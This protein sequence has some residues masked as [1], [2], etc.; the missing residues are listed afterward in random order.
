MALAWD[1]SFAAFRPGNERVE[2]WIRRYALGGLTSPYGCE[3]AVVY[4]L[5]APVADHYFFI[6]DDEPKQV[7]L[8]TKGYRYVSVSDPVSGDELLLG[9]PISLEAH[10]GRWLRYV[11]R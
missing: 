10:S 9:G 3:G 8:D 7:T 6:N 4:R 2:T 11:K 5:A 1:A